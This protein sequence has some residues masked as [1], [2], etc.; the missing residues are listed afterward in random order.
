MKTPRKFIIATFLQHIMGS[1]HSGES[2]LHLLFG[3][4]PEIFKTLEFHA[5]NKFA[6]DQFLIESFI[7]QTFKRA[8]LV[9]CRVYD[10]QRSR[11]QQLLTIFQRSPIEVMFSG[12][13]DE[14]W[15]QWKTKFKVVVN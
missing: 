3:N 11:F 10:F 4:N 5:M 1:T 9:R 7:K 14:C 15:I 12:D 13:I 6:S 2:I 8:Y